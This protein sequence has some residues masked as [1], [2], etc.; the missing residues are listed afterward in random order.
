MQLD[1]YEYPIGIKPE[2]CVIGCAK[3]VLLN[4]GKRMLILMTRLI[5]QDFNTINIIDLHNIDIAN[6]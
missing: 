6:E 5:L 3:P 2:F 1:Y 4:S